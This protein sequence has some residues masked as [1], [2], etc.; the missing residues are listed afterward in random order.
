MTD[1]KYQEISKTFGSLKAGGSA[2]SGDIDAL[3]KQY[4]ILVKIKGLW[5]HIKEGKVSQEGIAGGHPEAAQQHLDTLT[6]MRPAT[7]IEAMINR[8]GDLNTLFAQADAV[9]G[10]TNR[11]LEKGNATLSNMVGNAQALNQALENAPGAAAT[12]G[13]QASNA[14]PRAQ[15]GA[16]WQWLADGGHPRGRDTIH[17]MLSPGEMVINERSARKFGAQLTAMNAGTRPNYHSHGGSITNVGDINVHVAGGNSAAGTG[18][19][20][21]SELRRE[22]RRGSST[23]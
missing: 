9:A 19:Q 14:T 16:M 12:A 17:A 3:Q 20:I 23:L 21:A 11:E 7:N 22:L 10:Q 4:D 15:G 8:Q 1:E 18:R 5:D 13:G 2:Y 6:D